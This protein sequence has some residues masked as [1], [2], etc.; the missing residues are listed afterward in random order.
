[1]L[2]MAHTGG[3]G[4]A[5]NDRKEQNYG[6][7]TMGLM[8]LIP[9]VW[10]LL[11]GC[12]EEKKDA[13]GRSRKPRLHGKKCELLTDGAEK[14]WDLDVKH[15]KAHRTGKERKALTE[16]QTFVMERNC[17]Q[18]TVRNGTSPAQ[19]AQCHAH[20][21]SRSHSFFLRGS[22]LKAQGLRPSKLKTSRIVQRPEH[23]VSEKTCAAIADAWV[24][25]FAHYTE[26]PNVHSDTTFDFHK[27]SVSSTNPSAH[28]NVRSKCWLFGR[29]G[30]SY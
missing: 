16:E 5:K 13:L 29:T 7:F 3:H 12:E 9:T 18:Y 6:A 15:V 21:R 2:F 19:G 25:T 14:Y 28:S 8:G 17:K 11:T 26:N 10:P 24:D 30:L 20:A 1:M 27:V 22:R 4:S 23:V